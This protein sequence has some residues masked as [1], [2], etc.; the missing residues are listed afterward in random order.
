MTIV[1][2]PRA[3]IIGARRRSGWRYRGACLPAAR[4]WPFADTSTDAFGAVP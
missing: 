3:L 4:R 1:S 2:G